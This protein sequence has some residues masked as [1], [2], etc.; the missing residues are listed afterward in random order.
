MAES[1]ETTQVFQNGWTALRNNPVLAVPPLI[2][3]LLLMFLSY[4]FIGSVALGLTGAMM[5]GPGVRMGS[6]GAMA[7]AGLLMMGLSFFLTMV[8]WGMTV[9]MAEDALRGGSASLG[10]GIEASK[11]RLGDLL[12]ASVLTSI[13]IMIGMFLLVVPG[14]VAAFF[15][16][17]T[18]PAVMVG[19]MNG[20]GALGASARMVSG[21]LGESLLLAVGLI[22]IAVAVGIVGM[23]FH[24]VPVLGPIASVILQ[25]AMGA[26]AITVIVAAYRRAGG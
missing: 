21:R 15:L 24:F 10:S 8:A 19:G 12:I 14:I 6:I 23:I 5:G 26:Y 25:A 13:I 7:G 16:L 1:G 20:T 4:V 9:A 18:L 11:R 3:G 17:Y 22:V 2:A